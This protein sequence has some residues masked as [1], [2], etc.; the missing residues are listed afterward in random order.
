MSNAN[1]GI[2]TADDAGLKTNVFE[3]IPSYAVL[4]FKL[5]KQQNIRD[6]IQ[7]RPWYT[8]AVGHI[9]GTDAGVQQVAYGR[10][11]T[12]VTTELTDL[13]F[14]DRDA[15][16]GL[17]AVFESLPTGTNTLDDLRTATASS[18]VNAAAQLNT[19]GKL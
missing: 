8:E 4:S 14:G 3:K 12:Q 7:G 13:G 9:A 6:Y 10:L 18:C 2:G 15:A 11:C 19:L 1:C 16:L 17:W 5:D